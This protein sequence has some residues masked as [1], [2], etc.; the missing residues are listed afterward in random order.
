VGIGP[1]EAD[2]QAAAKEAVEF[3]HEHF[4]VTL[5][6]SLSSIEEV[7]R[8]LGRFHSELP[9]GFVARLFRQAPAPEK[10][11]Q[12]VRPFGTYPGEVLRPRLIG[13][14]WETDAS[15]GVLSLTDGEKR[16]WPHT[17]VHTRIVNGAE[18]NIWHYS[19]SVI[20]H[21]TENA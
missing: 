18:D 12:I 5:D 10:I 20:E 14:R 15:R 1:T 11:F 17:K 21:W 6:F 2:V 19:Q 9:K 7:E 13:S 8:I 16:I 4:Q 3:A